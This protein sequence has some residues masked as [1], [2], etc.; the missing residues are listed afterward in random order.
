MGLNA[1]LTGLANLEKIRRAPGFFKYTEH[2]VAA[3]S[4]R[5]AMIAQTLADIEEVS[6]NKINWQTLYEKSLNHDYTERFIGDIKTPVKYANKELRSMLA[7]V[8]ESMTEA[9][10]NQELPNE[11]QTI[12]Q[13]RLSEGKD[14]T[15]EGQILS[16]ADK[17]DLMYESYEEISKSNPDNVF[18]DMFFDAVITVKQYRE[19]SS[20]QYFFKNI[21]PELIQDDF[22]GKLSFQKEIETILND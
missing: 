1:F 2:T 22:Y 6:G 7:S 15:L 8:E 16:V 10:I 9:F 19:L 21:F 3:H 20:V 12:Y 5:V 11:F 14:D 17:I 13:R 4:F 18:K